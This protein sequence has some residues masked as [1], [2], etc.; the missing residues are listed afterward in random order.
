MSDRYYFCPS[1]YIKSNHIP[2]TWWAVVDE[3]K[4]GVV[5]YFQEP[6]QAKD[7]IHMMV[8]K[9]TTQKDSQ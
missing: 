1:T 4:G 2:P 8:D 7:F 9:T 6:S 3:E 5:A